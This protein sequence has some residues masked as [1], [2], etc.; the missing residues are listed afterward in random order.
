MDA[1]E[2]AKVHSSLE[3]VGNLSYCEIIKSLIQIYEK[4]LLHVE[5]FL[6]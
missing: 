3:I 2:K 4:E 6:I 5:R 1:E